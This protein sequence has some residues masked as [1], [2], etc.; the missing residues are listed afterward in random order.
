MKY[1]LCVVLALLLVVGCSLSPPLPRADARHGTT[2]PTPTPPPDTVTWRV[3]ECLS[4]HFDITVEALDYPTSSPLYQQTFLFQQAPFSTQT[5]L[6]KLPVI[7]RM[8]VTL[9]YPDMTGTVTSTAASLP[10][11]N[12]FGT[13][14][15]ISDA[16][17]SFQNIPTHSPWIVNGV[18]GLSAYILNVLTLNR[19]TIDRNSIFLVGQPYSIYFGNV[20]MQIEWSSLGST[21]W[22]DY[23][24]GFTS[25][26]LEV[27]L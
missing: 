17:A 8:T 25:Y 9:A 23:Q 5:T 7:L 13:N 10:P 18:T 2:L 14:L 3:T 19:I 22:V 15:D 26:I 6:T 1:F 11:Y 12:A 16:A 4:Q 21:S 27:I 24:T 20:G